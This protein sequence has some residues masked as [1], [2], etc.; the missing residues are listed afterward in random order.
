MLAL[1]CLRSDRSAAPIWKLEWR[2]KSIKGGFADV[3]D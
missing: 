1:S 2:Q 3:L